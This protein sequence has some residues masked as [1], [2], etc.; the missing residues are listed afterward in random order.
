MFAAALVAFSP[1]VAAL[2]IARRDDR[3]KFERSRLL[4]D[5]VNGNHTSRGSGAICAPR[6]P[7][8]HHGNETSACGNRRSL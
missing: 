8:H 4:R 3:R 5:G 2:Y 6:R 7:L 1:L